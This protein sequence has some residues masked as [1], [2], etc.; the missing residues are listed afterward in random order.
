TRISKTATC[1]QGIACQSITLGAAERGIGACIICS[2]DRARLA[3]ILSLEPH[4]EILLVVSLGKPKEQVKLETVGSD[5][6]IRYWRDEDG[7]HH[8]PKRPLDEIVID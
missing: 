6:N 1:D 4:Y 2:V 7:L 3:E 5:G 8:V